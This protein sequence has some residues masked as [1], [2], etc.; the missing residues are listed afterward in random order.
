MHSP[1]L[2]AFIE[3]VLKNKGNY[4]AYHKIEPLR[5][6]LLKDN[7]I[8]Q[9]NDLG[10]GS[11]TSKGSVR[12][13]RSIAQTALTP[14]KR[15]QLIHRIAVKCK[16]KTS[17]E[18]GTSLGITTLYLAT[19]NS[20][21]QVITFE[22]SS[23]IRKIALEQF[24]AAGVK[25]IRSIPGNFD[26]SLPEYLKENPI[27]DLALIDGN[28]RMEP[29]LRYFNQILEN[30]HNDSILIFDDIHW[31]EEMESAWETIV[32][33]DRVTLTLDIFFFGI[34]FLKKEVQKEHYILRF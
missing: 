26:S 27:I 29:T 31:S 23:E 14:Q 4:Y 8:I 30:C 10:A 19:A 20:S 6:K 21:G 22:G 15:A 13:V 32:K 7:R 33:D 18:L 9:V 17:I 34:V 16:A 2:F 5:R 24:H 12:K 3:E 25:N 1:F 28:H 11:K